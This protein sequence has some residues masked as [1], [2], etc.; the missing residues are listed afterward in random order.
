MDIVP[1]GRPFA[2]RQQRN[3]LRRSRV[4]NADVVSVL[5]E[6]AFEISV[7][8]ENAFD[9]ERLGHLP[10]SGDRQ[11]DSSRYHASPPLM[12]VLNAPYPSQLGEVFLYV[13]TVEGRAEQ[14]ASVSVDGHALVPAHS[15]PYAAAALAD[16][17]AIVAHDTSQHPTALALGLPGAFRLLP[18]GV[19][20]FD[21]E[22][23]VTVAAVQG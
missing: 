8:I 18:V 14:L 21:V 15:R 19:P 9:S 5:V 17:T 20:P 2:V 7:R 6:V 22:L 16:D 11:R 13:C 4:V 10:E 3:V 12:L 23:G 1:V